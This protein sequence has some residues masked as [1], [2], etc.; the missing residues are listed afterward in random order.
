MRSKWLIRYLAFI[1]A[2]ASA[3]LLPPMIV[4]S[5]ISHA[6]IES[7]SPLAVLDRHDF[8]LGA[9]APNSALPVKVRINNRGS[10]RLIVRE[11]NRCENCDSTMRNSR[12]GGSGSN[13]VIP[14]SGTYSLELTFAAPTQSG[15]ASQRR[16]FLTNDQ[17]LPRF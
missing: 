15:P 11:D 1:V 10:R 5:V 14:P 17:R 3:I 8:D 16:D 4:R 9:V 7:P 12:S 6:G 13:L 2:L